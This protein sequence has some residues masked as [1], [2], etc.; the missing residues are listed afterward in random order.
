MKNEPIG[1]RKFIQTMASVG[2]MS[3]LPLEAAD[4][5]DSGPIE[6]LASNPQSSGADAL[7]NATPRIKL[8]VIGINHNEIYNM[9]PSVLGGGG[10]LVWL[11]AKEPD[12]AAKFIK[13]FP[14]A[15][16][17]RTEDEILNDNSIQLILSSIIP[18][19]RAAL[20]IRAMQH[21]KDFM[22]DKPG[23]TTLDQ[24][25]E[26]RRVQAETKRIYF[27]TYSERLENKATVAA[28]ELVKAG[29]IGHVIQT[30]GLGP[31]R[32]S[33]STRPPWFFDKQYYGGVLCDLASHQADQFLYFTNSTEAEVIVSQAGNTYHA[34]YPNF[35]D[36]GDILLRGNGGSGYTRV[37]WFTPDGLSTWGDGRLTVLGTDGFIEV[38]K[39]LDIAGRPG[40]SHLFLVDQ[41]STRYI[42]T[43][44]HSLPYGR[45]LVDDVLNR[46]ETAMPQAHCF[47]A[48][49]LVLKAQKNAQRLPS[50][51]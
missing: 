39:N 32:M 49:E 11:Y 34:Q 35:E 5:N 45:E 23:V 20:G 42:D 4:F 25:A 2:A 36:F 31:H 51:G 1:R 22:C 43:A 17:A 24:L 3:A 6:Y 21:G 16:I 27:I 33:P 41:K 26:V 12:L 14:Q 15:K 50:K 8:A 28:G 30:V 44:N 10:E 46:T 18:V 38:R 13:Q 9:V 48:M 19:E 29:A 40:G 47:L 37:D 7:A